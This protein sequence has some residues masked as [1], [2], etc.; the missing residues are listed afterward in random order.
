MSK[1]RYGDMMHFINE[2]YDDGY[3]RVQLIDTTTGKFMTRG[4]AALLMLGG[5]ALLVGKK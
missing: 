4:E 1:A 2:L 5:S 3:E